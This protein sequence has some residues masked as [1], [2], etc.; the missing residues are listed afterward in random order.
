MARRTPVIL[1]LAVALAVVPAAAAITVQMGPGDTVDVVSTKI[2]CFYVNA[3]NQPGIG[4]Y[5]S[6]NK[7]LTIG[8]YGIALSQR[9]D[10]IVTKVTTHSAA[11]TLWGSRTKASARRH[12][13]RYY[14]LTKGDS[15]GFRV[16]GIDVGCTVLDLTTGGPQFQGRRVVCFRSIKTK[17]IPNTYGVVVSNKFVGSFRFTAK[18][19]I[20][21]NAFV[22]L[23]PK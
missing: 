12:A 13:I 17:P 21:P 20:G 4:C 10:A 22:R 14:S 3:Q 2:G 19:T 8:T 5:L 16:N 9:G 18:G 7:G 15:F 11:T 1:F 6:S 23:Q